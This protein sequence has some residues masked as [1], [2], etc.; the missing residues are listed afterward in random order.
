MPLPGF[1]FFGRAL[2]DFFTALSVSLI[3]FALL[4]GELFSFGDLAE[5]D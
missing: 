4:L 2:P 3:K 5:T 1:A